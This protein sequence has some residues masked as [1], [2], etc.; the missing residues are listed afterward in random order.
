[1]KLYEYEG[2]K[3]VTLENVEMY[4]TE[5]KLLES[6]KNNIPK[7]VGTDKYIKIPHPDSIKYGQKKYFNYA[8][9]I[10]LFTID[11]IQSIIHNHFDYFSKIFDIEAFTNDIAKGEIRAIP[12]EVA[13]KNWRKEKKDSKLTEKDK[14][15]KQESVKKIVEI[16]PIAPT[17]ESKPIQMENTFT[18]SMVAVDEVYAMIDRMSEL[19]QKSNNELKDKISELLDKVET[20]TND[21]I[22]LKKQNP[23]AEKES[24]PSILIIKYDASYEEWKKNINRAIDIILKSKPEWNRN[25]VLSTAYDR[26]RSQYG[27]VWEQEAKEFREEYG[28][29]PVNTRELCWWMESTK[30]NYKNLLIGKLNTI[31]SE[32]KRGLA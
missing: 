27:I 2:A 31:Y 29:G 24:D 10:C 6:I 12:D 23:I 14:K 4:V 30:P 28:R 19:Y 22:E 7:W 25:T 15:V 1:M 8:R 11:D 13:N 16:E 18:Q 26:L 17:K 5:P 32:V 3:V 20:L 9:G 21:I